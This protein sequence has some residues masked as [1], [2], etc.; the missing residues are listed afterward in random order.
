MKKVKKID[1]MPQRVDLLEGKTVPLKF[2][3]CANVELV[4]GTCDISG[5]IGW[6]VEVDTSSEEYGPILISL[7]FLN[8]KAKGLTKGKFAPRV[9]KI[10]L[11][12]KKSKKPDWKKIAGDI[13]TLDKLK[14]PKNP[15]K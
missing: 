5:L 4:Y 9:G 7:E 14:N 1:L 2:G 10:F 3:R 8:G 11:D 13:T 6:G 15:G 12:D